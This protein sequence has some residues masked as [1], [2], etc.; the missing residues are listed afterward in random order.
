MGAQNTKI[1]NTMGIFDILWN[2]M[3]DR[4]SSGFKTVINTKADYP[5]N[6]YYTDSGLVMEFA[7]VNV[8][9]KDLEITSAKS[10]LTIKKSAVPQ[11]EDRE[12]LMRNI[13]QRELNMSFKLDSKYDTDN[14][15]ATLD[16]GLLSINIP[17]A[18]DAKPK[19]IDI[20]VN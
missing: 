9:M 6:I 18:K 8:D 20:K 2:N 11:P 3:L 12:Y 7:M 16:K 14:I 15:K 17:L 13:A 4:S 5:M 19:T 1:M 10:T